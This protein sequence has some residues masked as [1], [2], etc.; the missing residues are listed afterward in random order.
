M[1]TASITGTLKDWF[2]AHGGRIHGKIYGDARNRWRDGTPVSISAVD[3]TK[4]EIKSGGK[5]VTAN[6]IYQLGERYQAP[7]IEAQ[8]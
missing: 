5:L 8:A 2:P 4:S 6:S 1:M 3:A 7:E